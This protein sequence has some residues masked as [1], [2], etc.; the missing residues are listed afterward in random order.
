MRPVSGYPTA[1]IAKPEELL[2]AQ[3]A[4]GPFMFFGPNPILC[5]VVGYTYFM[6]SPI[7]LQSGGRSSLILSG[8]GIVAY[9]GGPCRPFHTA[10][11]DG[12]LNN[13]PIADTKGAT[14]YNE[15]HHCVSYTRFPS[16]CLE[17]VN[18]ILR[19]TWGQGEINQRLLQTCKAA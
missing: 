15:P 7:P 4:I 10:F 18:A 16:E 13:M 3:Y 5:C 1:A 12:T 14:R 6:L 9:I 8:G 17:A 11:P 19:G 2:V